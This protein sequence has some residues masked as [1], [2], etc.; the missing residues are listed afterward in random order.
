MRRCRWGPHVGFVDGTY[1]T[2][3]PHCIERE[4]EVDPF[5]MVDKGV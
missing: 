1:S 4:N 5:D 3:Q 2:G